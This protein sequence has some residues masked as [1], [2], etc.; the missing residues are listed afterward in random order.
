[1][2]NFVQRF[3][4]NHSDKFIGFMLGSLVALAG[5]CLVAAVVN[6]A[7]SKPIDSPAAEATPTPDPY[8]TENPAAPTITVPTESISEGES[9]PTMT[10]TQPADAYPYISNI[11]ATSQSI[12][13]TGQELGNR[14]NV[15]S[16][17]GDSITDHQ[18]FL[19]PIG[20]GEYDLHDHVYLA[21][22]I[23]YFSTVDAYNNNSFAN[24][25]LAAKGGWS[26]WTVHNP[27]AVFSSN[28]LTDET[29]L[30]CEY[31][32]VRPSIAL[33][34]LGTNDVQTTP[35]DQYEEL[36]RR[37]VEVSIENGVIPVLSTIPPFQREGMPERVDAI[38][39]VIVRLTEE[40]D[41]PLWNYYAALLPLPNLGM[42]SDGI[43]PS[44][45]Y[46]PGDF[47]EDGLKY[48]MT[49]RNL[50]ALQ[51]LDAIWRTIIL[52]DM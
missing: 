48:G 37:T 22:V 4:E 51:A 12:Y 29:P 13:E 11:T 9:A 8:I 38:N 23:G 30:E 10:P 27:N 42:S 39:A 47:S 34:M 6:T 15:F 41:I 2:R 26:A 16:K 52:P 7:L 35:I 45:N 25:S 20:Y 28:C 49:V 50:T 43:H 19:T 1:M 18:A 36:M 44:W 14:P 5:A 33:I 32:L 24:T 31:R 17:V 40:Y 21:S 3:W 46:D